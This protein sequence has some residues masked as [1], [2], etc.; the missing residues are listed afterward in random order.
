MPNYLLVMPYDFLF[1]SSLDEASQRKLESVLIATIN[2]GYKQP[3]SKYGIIKTPRIKC[4]LRQDLSVKN[5]GFYF[6]TAYAS[7]T[8]DHFSLVYYDDLSAEKYD[9]LNLVLNHPE[10]IAGT[11]ASKHIEADLVELTA[12]TSF[13][14]RFGSR[15][16][17]SFFHFMKREHGVN[18]VLSVY[19]VEHNL[20]SYYQKVLG[21]CPVKSYLVEVDE[22]TSLVMGDGMEDGIMASRSF[23]LCECIKQL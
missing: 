13:R 22:E 15:L 23:T 21:F 12:F 16:F 20:T 18:R 7:D 17:E 11:I 9:L 6:C 10:N 2:R 14:A 3:Q 5:E 1:G 19:I 8:S 4:S